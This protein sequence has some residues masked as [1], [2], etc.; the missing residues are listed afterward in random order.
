M[1]E[2]KNNHINKKSIG[3]SQHQNKNEWDQNPLQFTYI[4]PH[5]KAGI[6]NLYEKH[7]KMKGQ[8]E[9]EY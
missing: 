2:K 9:K 5:H 3:N 6:M 4:I 7:T 8:V 1:R